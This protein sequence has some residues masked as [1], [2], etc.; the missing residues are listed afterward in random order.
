[1]Y[2]GMALLAASQVFLY[3]GGVLV[4]FIFAI[5]ALRRD[6][7]GRARIAVRF[8]LG[9]AAV[10]AGL[11]VLL[12]V[13]LAPLAPFAGPGTGFTLEQS[14]ALL[15]GDYLVQF[16]IVGVLLLVALVAALSMTGGGEDR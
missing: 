12:V 14:G 11:F 15:L 10:C 5:M 2:H 7:D 16:E 3:V 1:L 6:P 8:D 9:A 13:C 4:L